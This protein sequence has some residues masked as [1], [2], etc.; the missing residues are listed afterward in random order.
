MVNCT[1]D[2]DRI[3]QG[4]LWCGTH[5]VRAVTEWKEAG[6]RFKCGADWNAT[7][8]AAGTWPESFVV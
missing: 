4:K 5:W 2:P 1:Q 6:P 7:Q 3:G 8:R